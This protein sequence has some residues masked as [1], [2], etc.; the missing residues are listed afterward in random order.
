MSPMTGRWRALAMP[1]LLVVI[2]AAGVVRFHTHDQSS[3]RGASFGMFTTYDNETS[4]VVVVTVDGT[5]VG[6]PD[7]LRDDEER[8]KVVPTAGAARRLAHAVLRVAPPGTTDVEVTVWRLQ[9]DTRSNDL[10]ATRKQLTRAEAH[11]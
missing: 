6:L 3:W 8:L 5:R 4:R 10:V 9:L 7:D 1:A 2:A 11:P